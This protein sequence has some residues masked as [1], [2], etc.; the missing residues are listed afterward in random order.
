M[1]TIKNSIPLSRNQLLA[2]TSMLIVLAIDILTPLGVAV[3]VLYLFCF[4]LVCRENKKVI[5]L[6]A[7]ITSLFTVIKLAVFVTPET[8]WMVYSNRAIT[9][10]V[11]LTTAILSLRHR[12][13]IEK[14]NAEKAIYVKELEQMLFMTSH[15]VRQPIA[16]CL[17]LMNVIDVHKT[18]T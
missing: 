18:V 14:T 15:K 10:F 5:I 8:N 6:F 2:L 13:L 7:I 16:Q 11:I 4:F 9:L 1:K 12:T 3:G 17:G